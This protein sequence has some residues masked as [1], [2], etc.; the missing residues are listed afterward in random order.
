MLKTIVRLAW[1]FDVH[2]CCFGVVKG[3]GQ[4]LA[5]SPLNL[6]DV[7]AIHSSS[8]EGLS[9]WTVEVDCSNIDDAK[10]H[11]WVISPLHPIDGVPAQVQPFASVHD[12]FP[13]LWTTL[14]WR[15]LADQI[16]DDKYRSAATRLIDSVPMSRPLPTGP[17][18]VG[19]KPAAGLKTPVPFDSAKAPLF[20]ETSRSA[21]HIFAQGYTAAFVGARKPQPVAIPASKRKIWDFLVQASRRT[22]V[23]V[24]V[25]FGPPPASVTGPPGAAMPQRPRPATQM[26]KMAPMKHAPAGQSIPRGPRRM[27]NPPI[28]G[29]LTE[30]Q[31]ANRGPSGVGPPMKPS[32]DQREDASDSSGDEQFFDATEFPSQSTH[33][34]PIRPKYWGKKGKPG[35]AKRARQRGQGNS[36]A[37]VAASQRPERVPLP[38][39]PPSEGPVFMTAEQRELM[40]SWLSLSGA[41]R[42]EPVTEGQDDS[43]PAV[44]SDGP[45]E[46]PREPQA[47]RLP[48]KAPAADYQFRS[49]RVKRHNLKMS[50][51][52]SAGPLVKVRAVRDSDDIPTAR[53]EEHHEPGFSQAWDEMHSPLEDELQRLPLIPYGDFD[54]D[55]YQPQDPASDPR[56]G[57]SLD[58][59]GKEASSSM[60]S[61]V[62]SMADRSSLSTTSTMDTAASSVHRNSFD[63]AT[64]HQP[65]DFMSFLTHGRAG[66]GKYSKAATV[67]QG[68][69]RGITRDAATMTRIDDDDAGL[70]GEDYDVGDYDFDGDGS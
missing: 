15:H 40:L 68:L 65:D 7:K 41:S 29:R 22:G 36:A 21:P 27:P 66:G 16:I 48:P 31:A 57:S 37:P 10:S 53:A 55:Q 64:L 51:A 70:I 1:A 61:P 23:S 17:S 20:V 11:K 50:K 34:L 58:Y 25:V 54:P 63:P 24:E 2:P 6:Q 12:F 69:P 14:S 43:P 56:H 30:S 4:F 5:G 42:E 44:S 39:S 52:G 32:V 18:I 33:G 13:D 3:D 67:V 35:K 45:V 47:E 49:N 28:K 60:G 62:S 26:P 46:V 8:P 19:K 38:P 9:L 59:G